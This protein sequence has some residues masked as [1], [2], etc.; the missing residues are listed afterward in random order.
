MPLGWL[1][2]ARKLLVASVFWVA[3]IA[4]VLVLQRHF[5]E[6]SE[7]FAR[8]GYSGLLAIAALLATSWGA[9]VEAWRR[10][11][12]LYTGMPLSF[13]RSARHLSLLLLGKYLPG[14]IWG[15]TARLADTPAEQQISR[16]VVAGAFEQWIGLSTLALLASLAWS[17]F[18]TGYPFLLLLPAVPYVAVAG[19]HVLSTVLAHLRGWLRWG[20]LERVSLGAIPHRRLVGPAILTA[21]HQISQLAMVALLSKAGLGMA[22]VDA[23]LVASL[24]GVATTVGILV[25]VVPGGIVVREGVFVALAASVL[26]GDRA[27]AFAAL[28]RL[29]L[30]GFDLGSAC[31]AALL[32]WRERVAQTSDAS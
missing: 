14:G 22:W 7:L 30:A 6:I 8:L 28:V 20:A 18:S 24:Y 16:L 19:W 12:L 2:K 17:D 31:V 32:G 5:S 25:V 11:V 10:I 3:L 26:P 9:L 23:L 1:P 13:A 29:V 27:L 4:C 21:L 15:F